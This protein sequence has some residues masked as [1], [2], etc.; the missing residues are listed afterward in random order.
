VSQELS[1]EHGSIH[2]IHLSDHTRQPMQSRDRATAVPD[3]GLAGCRHSKP[4]NDRAVLLV[5]GETLDTL[6]LAPAEIKENITTHGIDLRSLAPGSQLQL[7]ETVVLEVTGPCA[8]CRRMD[9]IRH[10]LQAELQGR[11][12]MNS[13]VVVGGHIQ[14]GDRIKLIRPGRKLPG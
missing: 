8:P 2:A 7:G 10:G 12:G 13:R 6:S 3:A 1:R 14:T 5:E 4:G 9:E 11:R